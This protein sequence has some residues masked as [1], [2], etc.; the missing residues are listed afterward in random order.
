MVRARRADAASRA[1]RAHCSASLAS[2]SPRGAGVA[3]PRALCRSCKDVAKNPRRACSLLTAVDN[4]S[5]AGMP[6]T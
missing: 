5:Y 6:T 3:M 1:G 4:W 2:G